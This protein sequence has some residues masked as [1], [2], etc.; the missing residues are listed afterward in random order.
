M[1]KH[2]DYIS[3]YL[4]RPL[5]TYDETMREKTEGESL[6]QADAEAE[7]LDCYAAQVAC[8]DGKLRK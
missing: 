7:T 1:C 5:R 3:P 4:N 8:D 2:G 6:K